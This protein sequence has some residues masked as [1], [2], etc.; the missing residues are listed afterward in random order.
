[1]NLK[2][3]QLI[4]SNAENLYE[5]LGIHPSASIEEVRESYERK[6]EEVHDESLASYSLSSD[7]ENEQRL[8]NLSMAFMKL[9]DPRSR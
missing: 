1:M 6:L 8:K 7:E 5:L 9:A 2:M 3:P 4:T